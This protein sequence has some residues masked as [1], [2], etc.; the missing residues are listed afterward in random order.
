[1]TT[2]A[3]VFVRKLLLLYSGSTEPLAGLNHKENAHESANA[4][5]PDAA[6]EARQVRRYIGDSRQLRSASRGR[7]SAGFATDFRHDE[8][9]PTLYVYDHDLL[10]HWM[11][12]H[13]YYEFRGARILS[14]ARQFAFPARDRRRSTFIF[15]LND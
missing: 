9:V 1:M 5:A 4:S 15:R 12:L 7:E 13:Y 8:S 3:I 6:V 10:P 2:T 11:L 14:N